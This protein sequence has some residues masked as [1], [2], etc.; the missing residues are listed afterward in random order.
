[1]R[2]R[3]VAWIV[4]VA[5][6]GLLAMGALAAPLDG[7]NLDRYVVAGG[8]GHAALGG[9]EIEGTIGQTAAGTL[10]GGVYILS[11]GSWQPAVA[12][13]PTGSSPEIIG[14][15]DTVAKVGMLYSYA[16]TAVDPDVGDV[17]TITAPLKPGWL[18][19]VDHGDGTATLGGTPGLADVGSH[20]VVLR[21]RDA[22]GHADFQAFTVAVS[23][24][25]LP[26]L[27][28]SGKWVNRAT[29]DVGDTLT[30]TLV[31]YNRALVTATASLSDAIPLHTTFAGGGR[32]VTE[33]R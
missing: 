11:G 29:F 9:Y 24:L 18:S 12:P 20:N 16:I 23:T 7:L 3:C 28:L 5:I 31:L 6:V 26:D 27:S 1:M 15:P 32:P 33:V 19:L 25:P 13:L 2:T 30:Y 10:D 17:L 21:V 14:T 22:A 8:G 4:G